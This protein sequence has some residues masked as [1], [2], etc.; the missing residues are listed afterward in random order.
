M[1]RF[2]PVLHLVFALTVCAL[3]AAPTQAATITIVNLD[4]AGEG[5]NDPTVVAPVGGNPGVTIG[6]QRLNVFQEAANIWG[7][8]LPSAVEIRVESRF[9]P[10]SCDA[11]SAVLGSAGPIDVLRDFTGAEV[12]GTWYHVALANKLA[13]SDQEPGSNDI[14][15]TFNSSIDNNNNCLAGT[16]WYYGL[17]GNEGNDVELLPVVLHELGHGLGFSGFVNLGSGTQFLGF[18]DIYTSFLRD[19]TSGLLWPAMTN[20]QRAASAVNTGNVV[21]T[22][23]V[24]TAASP[25]YLGGTP[26]IFVNA[27]AVPS[28]LT[29]GTAAFGPAVTNAG[30][31][32]DVV[33]V[34]DAVAPVNDGCDAI[35]NGAALAGKIALIDRGACNFTV[36]VKSAQDEG[37]L[38]VIIANNAAGT[39]TMGGSDPTIT[40]P[41]VMVSQGDGNLIKAQLGVG[42]NVT[43]KLD[44]GDLAGADSQNRVQVYAPNPVE[45][46]SSISHWDTEALP[47]LLMEPAINDDLSSDV[48][49]TL[50]HFSDI[51][52][53]DDTSAADD[54][55]QPSFLL[56]NTPNPFRAG[57]RITFT[58]PE[59]GPASLRIFDLAGRLVRDL[60][61]GELEASNHTVRWDGTNSLGE[62]VASGVYLYRLKTRDQ[63]ETRRMVVLN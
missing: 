36:K 50:A 12:A 40:I 60:V 48:D 52:W 3:F 59:A 21:W 44:P 27:G 43:I 22:G 9:N 58:L 8:L 20:G 6:Q 61:D 38:A 53:V 57:T 23:P 45:G 2:H 62:P 46:G 13:G 19:N 24:V 7:A 41:A 10:Q 26:K 39:I 30:V 34:E 1:K 63:V 33:L 28:P 15:A 5:F 47:N 32:G 56:A 35:V 29:V 14:S 16:N 37:A 25:L 55:I 51:G 31:T 49:L 18:P 42:V 54:V 4:G 11:S 17:D